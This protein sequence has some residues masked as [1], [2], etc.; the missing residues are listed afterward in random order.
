[1]LVFPSKNNVLFMM[2]DCLCVRSCVCAFTHFVVHARV[3]VCLRAHLCGFMCVS[4]FNYPAHVTSPSLPPCFSF[5]EPAPERRS[6]GKREN[7]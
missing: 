4:L 2:F 6:V 5:T 1:M 3:C 7:K